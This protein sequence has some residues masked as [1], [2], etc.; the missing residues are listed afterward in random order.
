MQ[1]CTAEKKFL[2]EFTPQMVGVDLPNGEL[3]KNVST[4]IRKLFW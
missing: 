3:I 2:T 1:Y 4:K